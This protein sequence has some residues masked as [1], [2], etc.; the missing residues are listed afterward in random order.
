MKSGI[1][2]DFSKEIDV[3]LWTKFGSFFDKMLATLV[4]K[5]MSDLYVG[6][7]E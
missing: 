4:L 2:H 6:N 1:F 3:I 7:K 5:N